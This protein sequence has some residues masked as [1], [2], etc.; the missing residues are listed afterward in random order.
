MSFM[1]KDNTAV[2]PRFGSSLRAQP[3]IVT[4]FGSGMLVT[5][6]VVCAGA[7]Q[8]FGRVLEPIENSP[9]RYGPKSP[10]LDEMVSELVRYYRLFPFRIM[11]MIFSR[12]VNTMQSFADA[13]K[14]KRED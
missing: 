5:G 12:P 10:D 11:D 8:I 4:T 14:F 9:F 7:V 13:F 2:E 1:S 3:D 6:N